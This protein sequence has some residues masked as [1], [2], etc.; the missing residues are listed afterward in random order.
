[1]DLHD[2]AERELGA[3]FRR[4]RMV[5][6]TFHLDGHRFA[7]KVG[8]MVEFDQASEMAMEIHLFMEEIDRKG[9]VPTFRLLRGD[10][11]NGES[12]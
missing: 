6:V 2:W 7:F 1:M 9:C 3:D 11:T 5:P 4:G 8:S 12:K 10:A